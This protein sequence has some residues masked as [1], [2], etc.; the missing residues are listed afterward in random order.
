MSAS[1]SSRGDDALTRWI[2][3]TNG[4]VNRE[5]TDAGVRD[6]QNLKKTVNAGP[7]KNPNQGVH[8]SSTSRDPTAGGIHAP[9]RGKS[10]S[11]PFRSR[12]RSQEDYER[13]RPQQ[14]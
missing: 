13:A 14:R 3:A 6:A 7:M 10:P 11:S 4:T 5:V 1:S 2:I 8:G 9:V 12:E